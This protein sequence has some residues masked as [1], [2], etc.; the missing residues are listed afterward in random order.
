VLGI[1]RFAVVEVQITFWS[2]QRSPVI[3]ERG[4]YYTT[5]LFCL[6]LLQWNPHIEGG[7]G[8]WDQREFDHNFEVL[9]E[10]VVLLGEMMSPGD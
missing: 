8:K 9:I 10:M 7:G 4:M 3:A 5:V 1:V 6:M 2:N